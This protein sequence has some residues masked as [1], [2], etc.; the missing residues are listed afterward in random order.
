MSVR[1][2]ACVCVCVRVCA[3]LYVCVCVCVCVSGGGN[4]FVG[5]VSN[6]CEYVCS[7]VSAWV[8]CHQRIQSIGVHIPVYIHTQ[9]TKAH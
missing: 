2:C 3:W 4:A 6:K 7:H 9:H 1:V 8:F 5:R